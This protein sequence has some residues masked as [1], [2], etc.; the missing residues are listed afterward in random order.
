M[1]SEKKK[2]ITATWYRLSITCTL[3]QQDVL[4]SKNSAIKD[5]QY[6]LA[7]V[8]KVSNTEYPEKRCV[9]RKYLKSCSGKC[10]NFRALLQVFSL[11]GIASL[12]WW[13]MDTCHRLSLFC[14]HPNW[15]WTEAVTHM[16]S[17]IITTLPS[18]PVGWDGS[19]FGDIVSSFSLYLHELLFKLVILYWHDMYYFV[20]IFYF[21]TGPQRF[22]AD[23]RIETRSFRDSDG[24]LGLQATR[25]HSRRSSTRPGAR[26][27]RLRHHLNNQQ[28]LS[29]LLN[30]H[31]WLL[32]QKRFNPILFPNHVRVVYGLQK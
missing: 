7:R 19:N 12:A 22:D 14:L 3:S 10:S 23:V 16:S 20:F 6:E 32:I 31:R 30:Q 27:T 17:I 8:C 21:M 2:I 4:D 28:L 11:R 29:M 1:M 5:L 26:R 15:Y 9:S 25:I 13:Q 24:R 18:H